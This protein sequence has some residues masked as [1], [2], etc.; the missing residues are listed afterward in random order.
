MWRARGGEE[1]GGLGVG[2]SME[3]WGRVWRARGGEEY[4]GLGVGKS[5]EG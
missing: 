4:G 2:K 1:Y 5:M 3:G